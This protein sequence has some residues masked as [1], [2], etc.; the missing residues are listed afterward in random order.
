MDKTHKKLAILTLGT[1]LAYYLFIK[2]PEQEQEEEQARQKIIAE[3]N[4]KT[5]I[6]TP[7]SW[8]QCGK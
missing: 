1:G 2:L 6:R 3:E 8:S 4:Q 7:T 5:R